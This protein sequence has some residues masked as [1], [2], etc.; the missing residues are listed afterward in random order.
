MYRHHF[1][2][3]NEE[4]AL[5]KDGFENDERCEVGGEEKGRRSTDSPRHLKW[6]RWV[7]RFSDAY[8]G[9]ERRASGLGSSTPCASD[10]C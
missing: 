3:I 10:C 4:Q 7:D 2:K 6:T 8:L 9:G 5:S 1:H